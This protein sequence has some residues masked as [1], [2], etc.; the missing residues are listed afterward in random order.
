MSK[1]KAPWRA[2][3]ERELKR[4]KPDEEDWSLAGS[5]TVSGPRTRRKAYDEMSDI[6]GT[7]TSPTTGSSSNSQQRPPP[8]F[9]YTGGRKLLASPAVDGDE[10]IPA[11][12]GLLE[13][14]K[15]KN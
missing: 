4:L 11:H 5:T 14:G 13:L 1:K 10:G 8:K 15:L 9:L 12:R 3:S 2:S 7:I 6:T